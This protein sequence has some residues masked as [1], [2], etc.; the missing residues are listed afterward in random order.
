MKHK[1]NEKTIRAQLFPGKQRRGDNTKVRI[2]K[3]GVESIAQHGIDNLTFEA[4][5]TLVGMNRAQIRYHFREKEELV[6][7]AIVYAIATAQQI[8]V[9]KLEKARDWKSQIHAIV[10]GFFDWVEHYPTHGSILLLLYYSASFNPKRK[11]FH[12]R[13]T[14]MGFNRTLA[15]LKGVQKKKGWSESEIA[16]LSLT[17]WAI[18]DGM[19]IYH[20]STDSRSDPQYFRKQ[21]IMAVSNL[22]KK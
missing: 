4:V 8:V 21:A 13:M 9:S 14:G 5:G 3:A 20:L 11:E 15:I 2:L 16:N 10:H 6:D 22:L 19:M 18:T 7:R 1:I 17:I 12:T